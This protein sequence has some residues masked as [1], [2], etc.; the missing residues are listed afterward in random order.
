MPTFVA[1]EV[2]R[3]IRRRHSSVLLEIQSPA[4]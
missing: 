1:R 3:R 2:A 4:T